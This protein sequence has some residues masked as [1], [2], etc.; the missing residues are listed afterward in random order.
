MRPNW[1]ELVVKLGFIKGFWDNLT[2][3]K[4]AKPV[5]TG[6]SLF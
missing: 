5:E 3:F 6:K 2:N 1:G 4:P